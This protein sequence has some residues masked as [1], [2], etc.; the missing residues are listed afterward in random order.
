MSS[1]WLK[2]FY[3]ESF[4]AHGRKFLLSPGLVPAKATAKAAVGI[5]YSVFKLRYFG[6]EARTAFE[7]QALYN[8]VAGA[9]C[10]SEEHIGRG[11]DDAAVMLCHYVIDD[12]EVGAIVERETV[13][14]VVN[15]KVVGDHVL[16]EHEAVLEA[17]SGD[18]AENVIVILIARGHKSHS[19]AGILQQFLFEQRITDAFIEAKLAIADPYAGNI[20]QI[21]GT[22]SG[23]HLVRVH[24]DTEFKIRH[25][26]LREAE[27]SLAA[28]ALGSGYDRPR[29]FRGIVYLGSLPIRK[30]TGV[31]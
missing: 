9:F 11:G 25:R 5:V 24:F 15:V 27:M 7:I 6:L 29:A 3:L 13:F 19:V 20:L 23:I 12:G 28:V 8:D 26:K 14:A 2:L 17:L 1:P 30:Q 16:A 10:V 31:V 4:T 21:C 18:V 22:L